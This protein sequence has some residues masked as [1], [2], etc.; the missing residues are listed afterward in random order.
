[1]GGMGGGATGYSAVPRYE[2]PEPASSSR[3]TVSPAASSTRA[4]AFK[5]SGMKLGAKKKQN[6]LLDALGPEAAYVPELSV[7]NTPV[8][9]VEQPRAPPA[10]VGDGRGSVPEVQHES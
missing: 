5:G 7:P 4:P 3:P 2:A 6:D 9:A 8:P 10:Q 1:M